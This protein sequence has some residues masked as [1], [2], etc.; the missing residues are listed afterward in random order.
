M[1]KKIVITY[2]GKTYRGKDIFDMKLIDTR[3]PKG[4]TMVWLAG[5]SFKYIMQIFRMG[6]K[7]QCLK[8]EK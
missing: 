4:S 6:N 1:K 7:L 8:E 3:R 5:G 2:E